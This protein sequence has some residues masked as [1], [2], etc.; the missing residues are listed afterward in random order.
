MNNIGFSGFGDNE[1]VLQPFKFPQVTQIYTGTQADCYTSGTMYA[2][3]GWKVTINSGNPYTMKAEIGLP[4]DTDGLTPLTTT[5]SY[6]SV[7]WSTRYDF[8]DV[9]IVNVT[10]NNVSWINQI[11]DVDKQTLRNLIAN[12][13]VSASA[14]NWTPGA[15]FSTSSLSVSASQVVWNMYV[16]GTTKVPVCYPTF[17]VTADVPSTFD[18]TPF[19]TN[20]LASAPT[21]CIWSKATLVSYLGVPS[22]WQNDMPSLSD[23]SVTTTYGIPYHYGYMKMPASKEQN[24]SRTTANQDYKFGLWPQNIYGSPL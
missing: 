1:L 4:L 21:N 15:L 12:P 2:V 11:L 5:G 6:F 16:N 23:P 10:P 24:G 18:M 3:K 8:T 14:I 9:D 19:G 17:H 20:T 22:N 13:P 7:N